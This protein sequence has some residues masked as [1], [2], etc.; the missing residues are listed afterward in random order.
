LPLARDPR[1]GRG[2][3]LLIEVAR[4]AAMRTTAIRTS[5]WLYAEYDGGA[6]ELYDLR[7]DPEQLNSVH[8]VPELADV[9]ATLALRLRALSR[10]RGVRC[11]GLSHGSELDAR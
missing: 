8:A 9:R 3:A 4:G 10:C 6:T 7:T 1:L 11:H 5:R 2:R